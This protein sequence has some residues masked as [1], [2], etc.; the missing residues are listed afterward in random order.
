M[1]PGDTV[2]LK[3]VGR[4]YTLLEVNTHNKDTDYECQWAV[5]QPPSPATHKAHWPIGQLEPA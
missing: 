3:G 4:P 5:L 1:K 2:K